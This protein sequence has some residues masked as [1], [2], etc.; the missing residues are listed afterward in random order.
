MSI[1]A[2]TSLLIPVALV[3]LPGL[4]ITTETKVLSRL[5]RALLFSITIWILGSYVSTLLHLPLWFLLITVGALTLVLCFSLSRQFSVESCLKIGAAIGILLLL[6]SLFLLPFLSFH[7][8]LPSGDSEKAIFW[9][10]KILTTNTLPNYQLAQTL[11]NRDGADFSTPGLHTFIALLL[12]FTDQEYLIGVG[13]MCILLAIGTAFVAA[14]I[15]QEL[16]LKHS[17]HGALLTIFL[18]LTNLRFLRYLREP[19]YHLQNLLGEFLL[20]GLILVGLALLRRFRL[21]DL[22]LALMLAASLTLSH[23]LSSFLAIFFAAMLLPAFY[24]KYHA[25]LKRNLRHLLTVIPVLLIVVLGVLSLTW[26]TSLLSFRLPPLLTLTPHLLPYTPHLTDYPALIGLAW[27]STGLVGLVMLLLLALKQPAHRLARIVFILFSLSILL[28]SQG[29]RFGLDIPPTR[30][31][32]YIIIPLSIAAGFFYSSLISYFAKHVSSFTSKIAISLVLLVIFLPS[33]SA[34]SRAFQLSHTTPTNSSL[35]PGI[36]DL[37]RKISLEQPDST[38]AILVDDTNRRSTSW[39]LLTGEPTFIRLTDLQ[40]QMEEST[41]SDLRRQLFLNQLDFNKIFDLGSLPIIQNLLKRHNIRWAVAADDRSTGGFEHNPALNIFAQADGLTVY[42]INNL[43][44]STSNDDMLTDW[45][46]AP[47]TLANDIG[48][49]EDTFEHLA[50]SLRATRLS[51]PSHSNDTTSR[52]TTAPLI[53]IQFNVKQY[54]HVFWQEILAKS[55]NQNFLLYIDLQSPA[56]TTIS[57]NR[58]IWELPADGK[59]YLAASDFSFNA[60]GQIIFNIQN[61]AEAPVT[62]N[63]I[64][65]GPVM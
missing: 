22:L 21:S 63:L 7:Q 50:A 33:L 25:H 1:L 64:S 51:P 65:L 40:R 18:I 11:L 6:T 28:L 3:L 54:T 2:I 32:F 45:L 61:L 59:L 16:E 5:A 44:T 20:F 31:L 37:K 49:E 62:L 58:Q 15:S 29:P 52:T 35:T 24:F 42:T 55:P 12:K 19:G 43:A 47:T 60:K 56:P 4:L 41:Q 17:W 46:L 26:Q 14:S 8:G 34:T 27:L 48:D 10:Q 39:L 57:N 38:Q 9:A 36:L 30:L 53:P 23:Q 13:V